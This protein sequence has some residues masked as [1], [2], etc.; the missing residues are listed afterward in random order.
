LE[1]LRYEHG[2]ISGTRCADTKQEIDRVDKQ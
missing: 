2:R 1:E